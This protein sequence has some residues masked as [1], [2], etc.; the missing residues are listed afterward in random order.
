MNIQETTYSW[1]Y[2]PG[3]R[4]LTV[5]LT[6]HHT[7]VTRASAEEIHNWHLA[8][9]LAGI[10][11]HYYVRKDGSVIRGRPENWIGARAR[12]LDICSISVCFEGN[13]NRE[14]MGYA[15]AAAGAELT[16]DICLRYPDI[17]VICHHDAAWTSCPGQNF[18]LDKIVFQQRAAQME[19]P[20][21][22]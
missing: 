17:R 9:G 11:Y 15:Q 10:A 14:Q 12:G 8:K 16:A 3:E 19:P 7:A 1:A 6:L 4:E 22:D 20:T 18:P 13:F 21:A 2:L 5:Y